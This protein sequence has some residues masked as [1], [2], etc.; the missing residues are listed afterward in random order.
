MRQLLYLIAVILF[1][2]GFISGS[3]VAYPTNL[4]YASSWLGVSPEKPSPSNWIPEENIYVYDDRVVFYI[5][6]PKW[7]RF[8][9]TNS[10]DPILDETSNA[11]QIVPTSPSQ[12]KIGDIVSY[13]SPYGVIIHRVVDMGNDA[14]GWYAIVKGDN[15][16]LRDPGK[17][18]FEQVKRV[19]V[20][21][22]Y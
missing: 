13:D 8:P 9:D 2:G 5:D 18:R 4:E 16:P 6:T 22:I 14:E 19:L 20:A 7:A 12:I 11:I 21:V 15:N 3:I 10:M 1:L 17:V